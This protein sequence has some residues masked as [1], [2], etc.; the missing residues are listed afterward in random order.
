MGEGHARSTRRGALLDRESRLF[1]GKR[2]RLLAAGTAHST[3]D[4]RQHSRLAGFNFYA[5]AGS[6]FK[7]IQFQF[8]LRSSP[9]ISVSSSIFSNPGCGSWHQPSAG[10]EDA[11]YISGACTNFQTAVQCTPTGATPTCWMGSVSNNIRNLDFDIVDTGQ[12]SAAA[13]GGSLLAPGVR[14]GT[15]S[16]TLHATDTAGG[17]GGGYVLVNGL[18]VAR[19][20]VS[21]PISGGYVASFRPCPAAKDFTF[22]LNTEDTAWRNGVNRVEVCA[23]DF[24]SSGAPN[25]KCSEPL[26]I[27]VDN[28][29]TASDG[30][31]EASFLDA[32]LK[33]AKGT[34][35]ARASVKSTE[36]VPLNGKLVGGGGPVGSANVCIYER[37]DAPEEGRQLVQYAKTKGD[38]SYA[39]QVPAGPSRVL[40]VVYRF[41][42]KTL[43]KQLYV[44]A[45]AV[46]TLKIQK[47]KLHNGQNMRFGGTI[48]AP[49]R[50]PAA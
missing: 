14:R 49:T 32:E 11:V 12:P 24:A 39:L 6:Y 1:A 2:V 33:P 18:E 7:T 45:T 5:P 38:G 35:G 20:S 16:L 42:N 47:R 21:C 40:D 25:A 34:I 43:E 31:P 26:S 36:G 41:N 9:G 22:S 4:P 30:A 50:V 48:P 10:W 23:E 19:Q 13:T 37:I 27:V 3:G 44:D 28:S 29:C 46:P 8:F 17:V 15:E